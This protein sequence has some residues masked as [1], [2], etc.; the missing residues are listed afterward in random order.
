MSSSKSDKRSKKQKAS[1]ETWM[2]HLKVKTRMVKKSKGK[3]D[4]DPQRKPHMMSKMRRILRKMMK[5]P[6][7]TTTST[8]GTRTRV[9]IAVGL[10]TSEALTRTQTQTDSTDMIS[11]IGSSTPLTP[12]RSTRGGKPIDIRKKYL[13]ITT[14]RKQ[15]LTRS[16]FN[17]RDPQRRQRRSF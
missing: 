3:E 14:R 12:V 8:I 9:H 13:N 4:Q 2:K 17:S 15:L 11:T 7:Q 5:R 10:E 1:T 16:T 6:R